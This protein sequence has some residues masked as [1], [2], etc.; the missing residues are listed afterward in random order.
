MR[1]FSGVF[2]N[3]GEFL[4]RKCPALIDGKPNSFYNIYTTDGT[5]ISDDRIKTRNGQ[6]LPT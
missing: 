1:K 2:T 4:I 5:V 6:A 3:T